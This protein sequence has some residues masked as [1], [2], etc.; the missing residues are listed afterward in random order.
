MNTYDL[1]KTIF[2]DM[3]VQSGLVSRTIQ[4]GLGSKNVEIDHST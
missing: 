2:V 3:V 1:I 4:I